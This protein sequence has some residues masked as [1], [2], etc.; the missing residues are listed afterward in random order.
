MRPTSQ[1][2]FESAPVL[3]LEHTQPGIALFANVGL[4]L[5]PRLQTRAILGLIVIAHSSMVVYPLVGTILIMRIRSFGMIVVKPL[6]RAA[7]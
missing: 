2:M 7:R 1:R 4:T 5:E 6:A 3:R